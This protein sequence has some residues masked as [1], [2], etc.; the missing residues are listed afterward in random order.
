MEKQK[1]AG[2][3]KISPKTRQFEIKTFNSTW[4]YRTFYYLFRAELNFGDLFLET[5]QNE[6][7]RDFLNRQ[8]Y[9]FFRG[10]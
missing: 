2:V 9:V 10:G 8:I 6:T 1:H 3:R 4:A 7:K 5:N